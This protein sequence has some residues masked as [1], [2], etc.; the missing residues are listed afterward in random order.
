MRAVEVG[1]YM[2]RATNTGATAIIRPDGSIQ[3]QAPLF[4]QTTLSGEITAMKGVTPYVMWGDSF[5]AGF[6]FL[7]LIMV[8]VVG[9]AARQKQLALAI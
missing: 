7:Q 5:M 8:G 4:E 2:L 6:M 3:A 9:Y 1:R